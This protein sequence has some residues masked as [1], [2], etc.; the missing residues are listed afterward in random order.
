MEKKSLVSIIIPV[1]KVEKYLR[2]T[3][4]SVQKQTYEHIEI[5]LIDDG[6]PDNSGAICDELALGD[7]RIK[8]VH[9][10]NQGVTKARKHGIE[11]ANGDWI[12]FLDGDDQLLPN[13]IEYFITTALEKNVDIVQTPN[14]WVTWDKRELARMKAK[15]KY[16]KNGYLSL[17]ANGRITGGIGGKIIRKSLF[18]ENT[19]NIP[20]G[21]TN[22]EDMLMNIRLSDNLNS[23]YCDPRNGFYLYFD[24]EGSTT[25]RKTPIKNW[26][27]L[28]KEYFSVIKKYGPV[29]YI[30]IAN[31]VLVRFYL[32]DLTL[33]QCKEVFKK[34]KIDLSMPMYIWFI[35]LYFLHPNIFTYILRRAVCGL[36]NHL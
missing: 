29:M 28:Y 5:V 17:L 12:V 33:E 7:K 23:I 27:L 18:D 6:S 35:N 21:I 10:K 16:D 36:R 9:Q 25:K 4:E 8:V 20:S 3:V 2:E 30:F 34:V 32:K 22:N 19:L 1:Y 14:I 11:V 31:S 24:R 26:E 13:A 15:G